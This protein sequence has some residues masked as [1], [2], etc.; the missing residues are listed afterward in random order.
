MSTNDQTPV[1][2]TPFDADLDAMVRLSGKMVRL[3]GKVDPI[4]RLRIAQSC[5]REGH[6]RA[7]ADLAPRLAAADALERAAEQAQHA[8]GTCY[9]CDRIGGHTRDDDHPLQAIVREALAAYKA[10]GGAE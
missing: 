6:L 8:L 9:D 4:A 5:Y 7:L 1:T 10:A 2:P 3:S